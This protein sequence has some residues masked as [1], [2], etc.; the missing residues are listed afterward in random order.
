MEIVLL[1]LLVLF[2]IEFLSIALALSTDGQIVLWEMYIA[3]SQRGSGVL[4]DS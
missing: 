2:Y 1:A 4:K 3:L